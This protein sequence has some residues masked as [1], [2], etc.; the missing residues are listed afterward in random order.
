[1]RRTAGTCRRGG[2]ASLSLASTDPACV[3]VSDADKPNC[4]RSWPTPPRSRCPSTR[5][6]DLHIPSFTMG[7][8]RAPSLTACLCPQGRRHRGSGRGWREGRRR[9]VPERAAQQNPQVRLAGRLR[10]LDHFCFLFMAQLHL[11]CVCA[12]RK[13]PSLLRAVCSTPSPTSL[14]MYRWSLTACSAHSLT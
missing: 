9:D 10:P 12:A 1:M 14:G 13:S 3:S 11:L 2:G 8:S 4:R 7:R 6:W 5:Q